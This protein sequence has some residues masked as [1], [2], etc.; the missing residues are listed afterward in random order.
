M[1][2]KN[3]IVS[4][5]SIKKKLI[6]ICLTTAGVSLLLSGIVI[7]IA[8]S[9]TFRYAYI[10]EHIVQAKMIGYNCSAALLFNDR[11]AA[12]DV[13]QA[14][15]NNTKVTYAAIYR[16]DGTALAD[17]HRDGVGKTPNIHLAKEKG[18]RFGINYFTLYQSIIFDDDDAGAIFIESDLTQ[19]YKTLM[20][21]IAISALI[22]SGAFFIAL[23]LISKLQMMITEPIMSLV[24]LIRRI[25]NEKNYS[26]SANVQ[27]ND[28]LGL[29]A[30]GFNEMLAQI[31][32]RDA[33]LEQYSKFLENLVSRRTSEISQ[34]NEQLKIELEEKKVLLKEI[35][36]RV[37][38]NMQIVTSLINLQLE[39][40]KEIQTIEMF[41]NCVNRIKSMALLH[42][43][44]YQSKDL[45]RIDFSDYVYNLT[46]HLFST[47]H[48]NSNI[49]KIKIL[50]EDI[51]LRINTAIPCG[52]IIN[53]LVSNSLKYAFKDISGGEIE[54][55]FSKENETHVKNVNMYKLV[56]KDN[57]VGL[58]ADV[59]LKNTKT[60]GLRLVHSLTI[61]LGGA[62]ELIRDGGT[63]FKTTFA[64][65]E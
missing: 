2:I 35:H 1:T 13:L 65:S 41:K 4:D 20:W 51:F 30:N 31:R 54:I 11:I 25:S 48:V 49:V 57:G 45:A 61:Q 53:E 42:E 3:I 38:N 40:T 58:P 10:N 62:T 5:M 28:E 8:E 21:H 36:H 37:K 18:Y 34:I 17:Y 50:I 60:L 24:N 9:Y 14:L 23:L 15:K 47:Y 52:L 22:I 33:E 39:N 12:K 43:K 32:K 6:F 64:L 56:V 46:D 29:L 7:A 26:L 63:E 19:F 55:A 59:D 27:S 16:K 44:L